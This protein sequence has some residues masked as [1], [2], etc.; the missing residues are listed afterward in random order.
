MTFETILLILVVTGLT[1]AGF[2]LRYIGEMVWYLK[3]SGEPGVMIIDAA[4]LGWAFW[5]IYLALVLVGWVI[6]WPTD[7]RPYLVIIGVGVAAT[8]WWITYRWRKW[9]YERR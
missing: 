8:P 9:R 2:L 5:M 6:G 4:L 7:N 3:R 1:G